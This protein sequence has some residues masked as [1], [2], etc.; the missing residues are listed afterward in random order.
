MP[1]LIKNARILTLDDEGTEYE[2]ADI[3]VR[4]G[5]IAEIRPDIQPPGDDPALRVIDASGLLAMPGLVNGHMH[6]PPNFMKGVL[7]NTPLEIFILYDV[8]PLGYTSQRMSYLRTM[9]GILEM[10]KLGITAVNDDA[11]PLSTVEVIDGIMQAYAD[12]GMRANL[13][14]DQQNVVEYEKYPYLYDILPESRRREMENASLPSTRELLE[15][16][17]HLIRRWHGT[18]GGRLRAAVSCSAPFRVTPDYFAGLS[19]LSRTLDIPFFI[20][21]LETKLQRVLG[22]EKY[23]KSLVQHVHDLGYLD[24]RVEVIHGVW[25]DDQDIE[26][27]ARSGCTVAHNPISNLKLGS[28]VMPFR[29]LRQAG[30]N[31]CLGSDEATADDTAN[32]WAVAKVAGL[33]HK[34]ADPEYRNWPLASEILWALVRGGAQSMGLESQTGVLAAGYEADLILLD[35]NTIAFTP[36][37]NLTRQLVYCENGSSVVLTMVAGQIV[38]ERGRVLTVD[39]EAIKAEIR[40]ILPAYQQEIAQSITRGDQLEPYYREMYLRA[41]AQSVG[42]N[43]RI[44]PEDKS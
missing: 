21:I 32:M 2:R 37:N 10:V 36:L 28:G 34:I 43:R 18:S 30:V 7:E 17:D 25:I 39:E 11:Y 41:A 35:L 14:I 19:N 4:A 26:L 29:R 31:V 8:P 44:G 24:R 9:L 1:T 40:S 12:G 38:V 16:Y 6:S 13:A 42:M 27:L 23:H 3:L 20:H 15:L 33:V 22:I 5:K